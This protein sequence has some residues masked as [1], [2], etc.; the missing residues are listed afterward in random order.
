MRSTTSDK[1]PVH[2]NAL[3]EHDLTPE[4]RIMICDEVGYTP[5]TI[6]EGP[7]QGYHSGS[8]PLYP[9]E[10]T[11]PVIL[12]RYKDDTLGS[13]GLQELGACPDESG[14]WAEGKY[15]LAAD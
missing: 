14:Q 5:A 15:V 12:V 8:E 1:N 3:T 7:R 10:P 9:D 11:T 2:P 6:V 13:C 4:R